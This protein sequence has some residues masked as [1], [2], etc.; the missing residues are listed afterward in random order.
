MISRFVTFFHCLR[1]KGMVKGTSLCY[2][3][4]LCLFSMFDNNG[5]ESTRLSNT[6]IPL[7]MTNWDSRKTVSWDSSAM[8]N[9]GSV[10]LSQGSFKYHRTGGVGREHWRQPSPASLLKESALQ[11]ITQN[12]AQIALEYLQRRT[13]HNLWEMHSEITHKTDKLSFLLITLK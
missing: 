8:V 12:C 2:L 10:W 7:H 9:T 11:H 5:Y 6:I 4:I 1:R 13:I 3:V